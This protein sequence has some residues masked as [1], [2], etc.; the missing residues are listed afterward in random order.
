[1]EHQI[2]VFTAEVMKIDLSDLQ[3]PTE[4]AVLG[5]HLPLLQNVLKESRHIDF[6]EDGEYPNLIQKENQLQSS[7]RKIQKLIAEA[8]VIINAM[9]R[10]KVD[11]RESQGI[12]LDVLAE[13]E[14]DF[15]RKKASAM[16]ISKLASDTA[17]KVEALLGEI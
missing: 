9:D 10:R 4:E 11:S 5:E 3:N 17:K 1:M 6:I 13:A 15:A 2:G 12:M 7:Q 14:K 16:Y 8:N